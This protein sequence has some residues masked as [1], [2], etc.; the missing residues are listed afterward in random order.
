MNIKINDFITKLNVLLVDDDPFSLELLREM[1]HDIG[2]RHVRTANKGDSALTLLQSKFITTDL[3][4]CDLHMPG[5]DG[6][7]LLTAI[8]D[9]GYRN[10]VLIVSGQNSQVR[11]S[12]TL[13]AQL[14]RLDLAGMLEK[15][16]RPDQL[17]K[18]LSHL[19]D[20][21][22]KKASDGTR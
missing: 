5:M 9:L 22:E 7:Q 19:A 8:A 17:L 16:L 3:I 14:H 10:S 18:I 11:H 1:L 13:V 12:A 15:P 20:Q 4:I 2:V 21:A 6:F